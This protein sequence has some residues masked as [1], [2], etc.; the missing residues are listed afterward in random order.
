MGAAA[1]SCGALQGEEAGSSAAAAPTGTYYHHHQGVA[2][3]V[4]VVA[5]QQLNVLSFVAF[6]DRLLGLSLKKTAETFL[7][8]SQQQ[9]LTTSSTSSTTAAGSGCDACRL[10]PHSARPC[11][12]HLV[13]SHTF[14]QRSCCTISRSEKRC[15]CSGGPSENNVSRRV[16]GVEL[17]QQM[18]GC[19]ALAP[20]LLVRCVEEIEKRAAH[21]HPSVADLSSVYC[22]T[23]A[24]EIIRTL[25]DQISATGDLNILSAC[26]IACVVGLLKR[27]LLELPT[28]VIHTSTYDMFIEATC[29]SDSDD[30]RV[31]LILDL[32]KK[33]PDAHEK[34]L[35]FLMGHFGRLCRMVAER[36]GQ[37]QQQACSPVRFLGPLAVCLIRPQWLKTE[38]ISQHIVYYNCIL[39][40]LLLRGSWGVDLSSVDFGPLPVASR[41]DLPVGGGGGELLLARRNS[42]GVKNFAFPTTVKRLDECEWF[43]GDA[44]REDVAVAL[45][46][47]PDGTFVVRTSS[48]KAQGEYTLT[49]RKD[50]SNKLI[51]I[52]SRDG[53]FGFAEPLEFDSLQA[54]IDRHRIISLAA[55]NRMLDI[56]LISPLVKTQHVV[57][58]ADI[59]KAKSQLVEWDLEYNVWSQR[60]DEMSDAVSRA[61]QEVTMKRQAMEAFD[62]AVLMF[63]EQ[64]RLHERFQREAKPNE[65][66]AVKANYMLLKAR[67]DSILSSRA[68]LQFDL[69][70]QAQALREREAQLNSIKPRI[71]HLRIVC[72][73]LISVLMKNGVN[74]DD[75]RKSLAEGTKNAE[76]KGV[77]DRFPT[78]NLSVGETI[79]EE[80]P[81]HSPD[82]TKS[83]PLAAPAAATATPA[84]HED[85]ST[86]YFPTATREQ[87]VKMLTGQPDGTFLVRRRTEGLSGQT[88]ALSVVVSGKVGHCLINQEGN[89]F[90][91][92]Q[93][94]AEFSTLN[95][96]IV[97][98]KRKSLKEHNPA[99]DVCLAHPV[100]AVS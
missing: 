6:P 18:I 7:A 53:K 95:D 20:A 13:N 68:K 73:D 63:E 71:T 39:E 87:A 64:M 52:I 82:L 38:L 93:A 14:Q 23:V 91:F 75:V 100:N 5:Q 2:V 34:T 83:K 29:D 54:V 15:A 19:D 36:N 57:D 8:A 24:P 80:T 70:H 27:Y 21:S 17:S 60:H 66:D 94:S 10:Q 42:G 92:G 41:E 47:Q 56:C 58:S 77:P 76:R 59:E 89:A 3:V 65:M 31:S 16:F 30:Q 44:S 11:G 28:P 74:P 67:L 62:A 12:C 79:Y 84:A 85:S 4:V 49:L 98:Y 9:S 40:I 1:S 45:K 78:K 50:G 22:Q 37:Q 96:L 25:G 46:D 33:L 97:H 26:E 43:W 48:S 61:A 55:Y 51:R 99:L 32:A 35:R 88:H 69:N 86:W 90:G 72:D 81:T